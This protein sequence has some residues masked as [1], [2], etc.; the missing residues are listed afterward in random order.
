MPGVGSMF[1]WCLVVYATCA[2][3]GRRFR[4][5]RIKIVKKFVMGVVIREE[6]LDDLDDGGRDGSEESR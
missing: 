1:C 2:V 4:Q 3:A 5:G 6:G